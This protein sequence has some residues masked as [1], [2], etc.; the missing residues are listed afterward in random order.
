MMKKLIFILLLFLIA[1]SE[2]PKMIPSSLGKLKLEKYLS[3]KKAKEMIN[4]MHMSGNVAGDK[5]E[6]GFYSSDTLNAVLYISKFKNPE[7]TQQRLAEML[8]KIAH[9]ETPFS[10]HNQ[11]NVSGKRIFVAFGMG[12]AHYIYADKDELIWLSVDFPIS[13]ETLHSLLKQKR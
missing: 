9:G 4:K 1:C 3:G 12:Q 8:I 13:L 5:N 2:R 6:I 10:L 11:V 7:L